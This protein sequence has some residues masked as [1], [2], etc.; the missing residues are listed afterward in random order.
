MMYFYDNYYAIITMMYF[1]YN[2][3]AM[4][5]NMSIIASIVGL[6]HELA[7]ARRK[8]EQLA[9]A[10]SDANSEL[11]NAVR[12]RQVLE[13]A[14]ARE[15][16]E[17][18]RTIEKTDEQCEALRKQMAEMQAAQQHAENER[19]ELLERVEAC[20]LREQLAEQQAELARSAMAETAASA[21]SRHGLYSYGI[22]VMAE[23][24]ASAASRTA[25]V[26]ALKQQ[27][28]DAKDEASQQNRLTASLEDD[29]VVMR[30]ALDHA[31][32]A[33]Q[34][35]AL[36]LQQQQDAHTALH[37]Q[38]LWAMGQS[39]EAKLELTEA[40]KR[41]SERDSML[42]DRKTSIA[43]YEAS[44]PSHIGFE[45]LVVLSISVIVGAGL[46]ITNMAGTRPKSH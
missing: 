35:L 25:E 8:I 12:D 23:T 5:T 28:E 13:D 3:Y 16:A 36:K 10:R 43:K 11:E 40:T 20:Q 4:I 21:A 45:I 41:V 19:A 29:S 37:E 7:G 26:A 31:E 44:H 9:A 27:L 15:R 38:L 39:E 34:D 22:L 1:L 2:Y 33:R 24:A 17:L 18:Q 46:V 30:N 42:S 6:Q 14:A 32:A